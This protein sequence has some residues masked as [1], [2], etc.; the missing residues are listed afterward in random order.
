MKPADEVLREVFADRVGRRTRTTDMYGAVLARHRRHRRRTVI[1][2]AFAAVVVLGGAAVVATGVRG[3]DRSLPATPAPAPPEAPASCIPTVP[4][5]PGAPTLPPAVPVSQLPP[6]DDVRGSLA[7]NRTLVD[8]AAV[9]GWRGI[10]GNERNLAGSGTRHQMDK[11]TFRLRFIERAGA[12]TLALATAADRTGKWQ[13]TSWV[14][15][16]GTK[17]VP[18]GGEGNLVFP[19]DGKKGQRYYGDDPLYVT[20]YPVCGQMYGVVLAPREATATLRAAQHIG[21]D[22]RP[23]RGGTRPLPLVDGLAVFQDDGGPATVT[24]ARGGTVL[25]TGTLASLVG[26]STGRP[27]PLSAL[28][29]TA[30]KDGPRGTDAEL[31]RLV[32][33]SGQSSLAQSTS[34]RITGVSVRW[35]GSTPQGR[36]AA[37]V[38]LTLPSGAALL[39]EMWKTSESSSSGVYSGLVPAGRLRGTLFVA[40]DHSLV[41]VVVPDGAVRA[42]LELAGGRTQELPLRDRGAVVVPAGRAKPLLVRA[43]DA[44]GTLVAEQTP[45][46]GLLPVPRPNG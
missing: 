42:E 20:S 45:N 39:S 13:A 10:V 21:A 1:G 34:D 23:I 27:D 30:V 14:V 3:S 28:V 15:G 2:A 35:A 18:T 9:A 5:G 24:I 40:G 16:A 36:P 44:N 25:G 12:G 38:A 6:Q 37:L 29:G 4:P 43:Y 26:V 22:A 41:F 46:E 11:A 32:A 7:G 19:D 8:A 33:S 31:V 17:L